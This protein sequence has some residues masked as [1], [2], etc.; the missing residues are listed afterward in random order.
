MA[1]SKN[2][3]MMFSFPETIPPAAIPMNRALTTSRSQNASTIAM[4]G[5]RTDQNP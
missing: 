1:G 5:G 3:S 2:A 4:R